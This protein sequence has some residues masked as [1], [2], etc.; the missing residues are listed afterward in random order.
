VK[1]GV[2]TIYGKHRDIRHLTTFESGGYFR[3][4]DDVLIIYKEDQTN[5]N[6]VLN[7]FNNITPGLKFTLEHEQNNKINFLHLTIS[8]DIKTFS[9]NIYRKP[10]TTDVIIPRDSCHP[11]EQKLTAIRYF[12]NRIH[13]YSLDPENKQKEINTLKQIVYNNK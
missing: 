4:V 3:Y 12:T 9:V 2:P 11:I 5:I 8:R 10:A 7:Q 1:L 13:K 6:E